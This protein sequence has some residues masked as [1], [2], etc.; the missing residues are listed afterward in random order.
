MRPQISIRESD[1]IKLHDSDLL[2]LHP[3]LEALKEIY[4]AGDLAIFPATHNDFLNH[5]HFE[6]QDMLESGLSSITPDGWLNRFLKNNNSNNEILRAVSLT[7]NLAKVFQGP[8]SVSN[9]AD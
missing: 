7:S 8:Y 5:S 3:R 4:E 2:G 1:T 6:S 9:F